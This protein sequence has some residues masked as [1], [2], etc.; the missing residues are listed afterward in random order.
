MSQVRAQ[1]LDSFWP[2]WNRTSVSTIGIL[3]Q[4]VLVKIAAGGKKAFC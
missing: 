1:Y 3:S 2:E 4:L